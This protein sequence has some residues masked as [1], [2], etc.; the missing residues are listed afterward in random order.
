MMANVLTTQIA[1]QIAQ[2]VP[3]DYISID[4]H[5]QPASTFA[6]LMTRR[7]WAHVARSKEV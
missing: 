1:Y 2:V 7:L 5:D 3:E 6:Q 4:E